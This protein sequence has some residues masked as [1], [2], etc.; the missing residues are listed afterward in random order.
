MFQVSV[1]VLRLRISSQL[2]LAIDV[3]WTFLSEIQRAVATYEDKNIN[4]AIRET[5]DIVWWTPHCIYLNLILH[6]FWEP[7]GWISQ[8]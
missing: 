3:L 1:P 7:E 4:I 8:G 6:F 5:F 2:V